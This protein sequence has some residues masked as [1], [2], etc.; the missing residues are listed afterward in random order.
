MKRGR[1]RNGPA[2]ILMGDFCSTSVEFL[3]VPKSSI[4]E[5]ERRVIK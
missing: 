3:K 5:M 4:Y 2:F 1:V